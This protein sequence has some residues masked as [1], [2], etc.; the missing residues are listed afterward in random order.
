MSFEV[1]RQADQL[2]IGAEAE[3]SEVNHVFAGLVGQNPGKG[4]RIGDTLALNEGIPNHDQRG[5][6]F[7]AGFAGQ[8]R[9]AVTLR[10]GAGCEPAAVSHFDFVP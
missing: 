8:A 9:Q 4:V 10:V 5:A 2:L 3:N 1:V 6:G 7:V